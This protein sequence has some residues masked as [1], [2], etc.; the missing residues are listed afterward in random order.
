MK[1]TESMVIGLLISQCWLFRDGNTVVVVVDIVG[2]FTLSLLQKGM[3]R[4]G[5]HSPPA[6]DIASPLAPRTRAVR[7][8][9]CPPARSTY[10]KCRAGGTDVR[11]K[12]GCWAQSATI[13]QGRSTVLLCVRSRPTEVRVQSPNRSKPPQ[14]GSTVEHVVGDEVTAFTTIPPNLHFLRICLF[15][16]LNSVVCIVLG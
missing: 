14:L 10:S 9:A 2:Y 6:R 8:R 3:R 1:Y 15:D 13:P 4:S 11:L 12:C 5:R 7:T 16:L